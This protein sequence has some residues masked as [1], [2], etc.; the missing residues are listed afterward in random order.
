MDRRNGASVRLS[1]VAEIRDAAAEKTSLALFNGKP[2]LVVHIVKVQGA[3]TIAV[4]DGVFAAV[5]G[6]QASVRDEVMLLVVRDS[7]KGILSSVSNVRSTLVE[8]GLLTVAIV[9]LFLHSWRSTVTIGRPLPVLVI[10]TFAALDFLGF[11]LNTMTLMALSLAV[12][13]LIDDANVVRENISRHLAMSKSHMRA[14]W[15]SW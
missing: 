12:G 6:L 14:E 3:N 10:G 15:A 9:F 1:D 5:A 11:T 8:G 13:I 4:A 7:S 2:A